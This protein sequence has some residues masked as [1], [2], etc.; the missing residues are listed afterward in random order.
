MELPRAA[1]LLQLGTTLLLVALIWFVQVVAYPLFA[2][3]AAADF[4][5]YHASHSRLITYVNAPLMVGELASSMA[6][7]IW[8]LSGVP[9]QVA[10]VGAV[11]AVAT[12]VVT[13]FVS[14]R[15]QDILAPGFDARA[16]NL[17]V[18]TNWLRTASGTAR[19]AILLWV[20]AVMTKTRG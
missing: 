10:W 16:H 18:A 5:A 1:L 14:V 4:L 19:G 13:M 8:P 17:L 11:L 7:L 2:R 12:W 20:I 15:Q 9:R 6:W 3:V